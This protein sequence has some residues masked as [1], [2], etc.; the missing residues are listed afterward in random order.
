L[1]KIEEFSANGSVEFF[2]AMDVAL[3]IMIIER[4]GL[5]EGIKHI[6]IPAR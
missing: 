6:G 5:L 1:S 4:R 2:E 3:R